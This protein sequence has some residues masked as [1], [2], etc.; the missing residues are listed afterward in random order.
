MERGRAEE[1]QE[2]Q[3]GGFHGG[4]VQWR[5][6]SGREIRIRSPRF[7]TRVLHSAALDK[8]TLIRQIIA[9]LE[10]E[11]EGYA[12]SARA[13]H[14]EATDEQSK[15]ENKYDTRGLE[16]S[17]LAQGQ[18]RQAADLIEAIDH[19]RALPLRTF[20]ADEPIA[21][22]AGIELERAG[23]RVSYFLAPRA[24]GTEVTHRE[25]TIILITPPSPIGRELIGRRAGDR[26]TLPGAG[27]SGTAR[28]T[29]VE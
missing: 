18:S 20:A 24:G 14:A 25:R 28:I 19:I 2:Q 15:A 8:P 23:E 5:S 9:A 4:Q 27:K 22:G 13:A 1:W 3:G 12:R 17:Y 16:A 6:K 10:E 26:V 7:A 11:L 21:I 29:K